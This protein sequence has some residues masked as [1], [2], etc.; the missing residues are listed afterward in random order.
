MRSR[1]SS[2]IRPSAFF[3]RLRDEHG[4]T[5]G[6]TIIKDYMRDRARR[7]QEMFVP[8]AHPAGHAQADFGE[9]MVVIG[10]VEQKAHFFVLDLPHSDACYVRAYPAAVAEAWVDGH[11]HAF[12]FFGA[13]P[14]SIV[15]DNDRCLVA[16]ILPDG[17]RK[18][19]ALFSGFLSHYL[20]RDRYGRPGKGNDKGSVEGLV[21]YAR[22]NFM[23]PIPRFA[24]WDAF[25]LWLEEQCRKRQ[26]DRLRGAS[27]TIGERLLRD[28]AAM[29]PLPASPFEACDQASGRVS[30]QAL[31]RYRTNDY[32]V[33]VAFGHQDVWI[34]G[35][36]DEVAIGCGGE[37]IARHPRSYAREEVVFDPLHYLPLIEQKINA[38]DQAAPLQGWELPEAFTT[39]RRLMEARMGKQGRRAYV[40]VLRLMESFDLADLHAAVKQALHLGA[41]SFDA[42][43]HLV[44]CRAERRP[45]RLDLDIYPYLPRATVETTSAKAYM[46][47]LDRE[48]EPA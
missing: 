8:L 21:G 34:R 24:S 16:K 42:V 43:K 14:Q 40:Q 7:G 44:L 35:Y 9:A 38:L 18:R 27:E 13:V 47:L 25:N 46:R 26:G 28:V 45:P 22:R 10:G 4:F 11:I 41:I 30:S 20:I 19:A 1:A 29:R 36:V 3:D 39:L 17:T 23:V 31:V 5:G 48:E 2:V 6:Y 12:A 33:P 37:I 32:S 15:Y